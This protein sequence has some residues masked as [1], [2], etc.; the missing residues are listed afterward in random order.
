[1]RRIRLLQWALGLCALVLWGRLIQLQAWDHAYWKKR[2]EQIRVWDEPLAARRGRLLDR[3]GRELADNQPWVEGQP[4]TPQRQARLA[5][6]GRH[7]E[8]KA[9]RVYP[10]GSICGHLLGYVSERHAGQADW[11]GKE[12]L[13]AR[14]QPKLAGTDGWRRWLVTS[15]GEKLR[16]LQEKPAHPGQ[17]VRLTL[18][19]PLQQTAASALESV[20]HQLGSVRAANDQPA[21]AVVVMEAETGRVLA[22]VSLPTFDPNLFVHTG[23]DQEIRNLLK[24]PR[25]PLLNRAIAGQVPAASTFKIITASAA[26]HH[27]LIPPLRQFYCPGVRWI[28]GVPF[29]CFVRRG[30]G[31]LSFEQ[32]LAYSCDCAYY[33]LGLE[34][35]GTQLT[36]WARLWG[37]GKTTGVPLPGEQPGF[38]PDLSK[39]SQGE[40]A[41]LSIGQG[42]LLVTPLQMACVAAGV[43]NRGAIPRPTL[44]YEKPVRLGE[45]QL[46]ELEWARIRAGLDGAVSQGTA[47]GAGGQG[48][49]LAGKTGTVENSP[50]SDNPRG[51]NHAWFVGYGQGLAIAVFL[52]R[53]G[54]YG[55]ALAAPIAVSV[56]KAYSTSNSS[57]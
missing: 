5:E 6:R 49:G 38:L 52:E 24:D 27:G 51:Y 8:I 18:D 47:A 15:Q 7:Y 53:S 33:D 41:N 42:D 9:Q 23:H 22:M 16:L 40:R 20:L 26:M 44:F 55:G 17:D 50:S 3:S 34:L 30:H 56:L 37:L 21:G 54:G 19:L 45:I 29:H 48:L 36:D 39:A 1:M 4:L 57:L 31:N 10:G 13:E 28:G 25:A 43:N 35:A 11:L 32:T 12:G 2:G 46:S 14:L